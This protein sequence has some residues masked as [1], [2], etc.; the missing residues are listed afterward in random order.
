MTDYDLQNSIIRELEQMK[1]K[2]PGE[3]G[4]KKIEIYK[5][6]K[7]FRD[8]YQEET[9]DDYIIIMLGDETTD[10]DGRWIVEVQF[11]FQ[12]MSFDFKRDGE[13]ILTNLMNQI[14][15]HFTKKGIIDGK[16][17]LEKEKAKA[18]NP[19]CDANY[20]QSAYVTKWKIPNILVEMEV[21][22]LI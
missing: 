22:N 16:Y 18:R 3:N 12:I 1:L 20:A 6:H 7:P 13:Q 9:T 21:G 17:E 15:L 5:Q 4:W 2:I 19:L 8:D 11:L 14:D 10:K